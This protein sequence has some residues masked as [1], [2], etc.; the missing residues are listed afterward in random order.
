MA[1]VSSSTL[2]VASDCQLTVSPNGES[3]NCRTVQ[4]EEAVLHHKPM[5]TLVLDAGERLCCSG[6][7]LAV[8]NGLV[9]TKV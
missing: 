9:E 5:E 8:G 1:A 2:I 7:F 3:S 6:V 4:T